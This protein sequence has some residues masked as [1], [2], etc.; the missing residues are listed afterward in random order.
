MT[1]MTKA[2]QWKRAATIMKWLKEGNEH[3][4]QSYRDAQA[5]NV[6]E[7]IHPTAPWEYPWAEVVSSIIKRRRA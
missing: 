7:V 1:V 6:L 4:T 2:E 3:L 5:V